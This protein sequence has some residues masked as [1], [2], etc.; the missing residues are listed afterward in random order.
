M[1]FQTGP[2]AMLLSGYLISFCQEWPAKS[3]R[4]NDSSL[5]YVCEVVC[6]R[7]I[8]GKNGPQK[9]GPRSQSFPRILWNLWGS[10][11]RFCRTFHRVKSL[12]KK[13]PRK[14][15]G[16]AELW[17]PGPS[18]SGPPNSSAKG[19]RPIPWCQGQLGRSSAVTF[20]LWPEGRSTRVGALDG[21]NRGS[22]IR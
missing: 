8:G 20:C 18:F 10:A 22:P 5:L 16:S 13:V 21:P 2:W 12:S 11:G 1:L 3:R 6:V 4:I 15:K 7:G 14:Q 19:V 9:M 17:E